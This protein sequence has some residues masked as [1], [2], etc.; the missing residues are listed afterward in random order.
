MRFFKYLY[1]RIYTWD[2]NN[3]GER[4][5][6]QF[7]ALV[8]VL[9]LFYSNI[10][11]ILELLL[12]FFGMHL[13]KAN[14]W[15]KNGGGR[16]LNL[17]LRK[18]NLAGV[19][20]FMT[21]PDEVGAIAIVNLLTQSNSLNDGLVYGNITLRLHQNSMVRAFPDKYDFDMHRPLWNPLN[22]PRNLETVIGAA[23]AGE[24]IPFQTNL[25]G[26]AP[27]KLFPA[28]LK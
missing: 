27:I 10:F 8:G 16:T 11:T 12:N 18:L 3:W 15:Y 1:W 17:D 9:F 7:K 22:W 20:K 6:P 28:S 13:P 25:N 5:I 4:D 26:E 21:F 19:S 23:V 24:G 14:D 2:V